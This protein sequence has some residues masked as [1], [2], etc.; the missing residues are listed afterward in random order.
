MK[1]QPDILFIPQEM[2]RKP[3]APKYDVVDD[4]VQLEHSVTTGEDTPAYFALAEAGVLCT[5]F[6]RSSI[7]DIFTGND[8]K[9]NSDSK[10]NW[11]VFC[12]Y[13]AVPVLGYFAYCT[14]VSEFFI[15][16]AHVGE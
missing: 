9:A 16:A 10:R 12:A 7:K 5:R 3:P 11:K 1:T 6:R 8:V 4:R 15:P 14:M 13:N 2:Q